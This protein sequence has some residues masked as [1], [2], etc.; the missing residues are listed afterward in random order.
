MAKPKNRPK[1][2]YDKKSTRGLYLKLN[3]RTD[4]DILAKLDTVGN[5]QGYIK[6]LVRADISKGSETDVRKNDE[7][8][9][10]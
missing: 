7:E 3:I 8:A 5:K 10:H 9:I 4:A 2:K 1:A 6:N